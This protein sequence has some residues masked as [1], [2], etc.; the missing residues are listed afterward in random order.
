MVADRRRRE[1][2]RLEQPG[3]G[4]GEDGQAVGRL[5]DVVHVRL[6]AIGVF[7]KALTLGSGRGV[8]AHAFGELL[9]QELFEPIASAIVGLQVQIEA[10]DRKRPGVKCCEAVE[11]C[12]ELFKLWH[13][14]L[15]YNGNANWVGERVDSLQFTVDCK[16][17]V[18]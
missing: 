14:Q 2:D 9:S 15:A 10:D 6:D 13:D 1:L 3:A 12:I 4:T 16:R 5:R 11:L 8:R 7:V 18:N 17:T